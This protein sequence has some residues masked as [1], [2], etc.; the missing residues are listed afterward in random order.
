MADA[1]RRFLDVVLANNATIAVLT[2][3]LSDR[4]LDRNGVFAGKPRA[5]PLD[6]EMKRKPL[7]RA[8]AE[9]FSAG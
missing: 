9:A 3:G 8:M 2:W 6:A 1:S 7:W 5:L 4:Y